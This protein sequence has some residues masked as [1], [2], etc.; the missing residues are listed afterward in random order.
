ALRQLLQLLAD[1]D[2]G[3]AGRDRIEQ[4]AELARGGG[5][6]IERVQVRWAAGEVHHDHGPVGVVL[7][8][9]PA[10]EQVGQGKQS[11]E[12]PDAE[13]TPAGR[14]IQAHHSFSGSFC[15]SGGLMTWMAATT[16]FLS[17]FCVCE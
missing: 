1:L 2:A 4:P 17:A 16:S 5:L 12:A 11:A 9:G 14:T 6:E 3:D 8:S 13:E 7:L 15:S 10:T